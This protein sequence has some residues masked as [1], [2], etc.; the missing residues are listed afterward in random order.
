MWLSK[1]HCSL[2]LF[3]R[4]IKMF[5]IWYFSMLCFSFMYNKS[6]LLGMFFKARLLALCNQYIEQSVLTDVT[7]L[8]SLNKAVEELKSILNV[9]LPNIPKLILTVHKTKKNARDRDNS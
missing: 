9:I 7:V 8:V 6:T 1:I 4:A 2:M 3:C 5:S